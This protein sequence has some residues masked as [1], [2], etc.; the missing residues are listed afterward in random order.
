MN[1]DH[2][3][4]KNFGIN[5]CFGVKSGKNILSVIIHSDAKAI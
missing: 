3:H 5:G 1:S 4:K 2:D